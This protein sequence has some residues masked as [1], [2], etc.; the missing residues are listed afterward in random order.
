MS[1]LND[2]QQQRRIKP[3]KIRDLGIDPYPADKWE[4]NAWSKD[5]LK[6]YDPE[7]NNFQDVSMAGR[8]M[9]LQ[10]RGKMSFMKIQDDTGRLQ[11][12]IS[13]D[14]ICPGEDKTF[15]DTMVLHLLDIGDFI[16]VKG[17]V[18]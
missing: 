7:Q 2:L 13:R 6:S 4:V 1:E 9:S 3:G 8:I 12:F 11:L 18:F 10:P 16:G 17:E 15:F 14:M 5:I